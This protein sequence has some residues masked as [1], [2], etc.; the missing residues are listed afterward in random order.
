MVV[1][2]CL[3]LPL[4]AG[5]AGADGPFGACGQ[6]SAEQSGQPADLAAYFLSLCLPGIIPTR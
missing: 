1:L 3:S 6:N 4:L 2:S 5:L